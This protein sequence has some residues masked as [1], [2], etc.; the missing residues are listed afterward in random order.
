MRKLLI[1]DCDGTLVDTLHDVSLCFNMALASSGF[2]EHPLDAYG[3]FVGGNL[4]TIVTRLLP[5]E[6]RNAENIERV[7]TAYRCLYANSEKKNTLPYPG[8]L[9]ALRHLKQKGFVLAV[10]TNKGQQLTDALLEQLFPNSLFSAVVGYDEARPSKPDP[11]GVRMICE[12]C[13]MDLEQAIYIG[14]G[15]SDINTAANAGI[16]CVFVTWGQGTEEDS[17]DERIHAVV[18]SVPEMERILSMG[19]A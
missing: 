16:P 13:G 5:V 3:G 19:I 17:R 8:I 15:R 9:D 18:D 4:E 6:C 7:K 11:Y 2:P 12:K 14:D 10:N 1:F